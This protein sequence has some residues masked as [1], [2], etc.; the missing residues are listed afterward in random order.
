MAFGADDLQDRESAPFSP[1]KE[2]ASQGA[3]EEAVE[4]STPAPLDLL[5]LAKKDRRDARQRK[6]VARSQG[7]LKDE[8]YYRGQIAALDALIQRVPDSLKQSNRRLFQDKKMA[9][10]ASKGGQA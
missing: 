6:L 10:A 3:V 7:W 4:E 1:A 8:I 5:Q 2:V 9:P